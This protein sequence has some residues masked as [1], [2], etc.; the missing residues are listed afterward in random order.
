MVSEVR[1]VRIGLLETGVRIR[2]TPIFPSAIRAALD[3]RG[4]SLLVVS[5]DYR[6]NIALSE[7]LPHRRHHL[8]VLSAIPRPG[9]LTGRQQVADSTG[10]NRDRS[11]PLEPAYD[12][13]GTAPAFR[14]IN[15]RPAFVD[16][17]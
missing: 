12:L 10:I 5:I 17:R 13:S 11:S 3:F 9:P 7:R 14:G 1:R 16:N 15:D 4:P 8:S 6:E 2:K